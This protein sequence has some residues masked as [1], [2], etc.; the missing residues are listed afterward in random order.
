MSSPD[1][2]FEATPDLTGPDLPSREAMLKRPASKAAH[3]ELFDALPLLK[4]VEVTPPPAPP[5]APPRSARIAF[6][7]A[8]RCKFV[9]ASADLIA[10]LRPDALLLAEMDR[11]MARSGQIHTTRAL[12]Q[13]LEMGGVFGA[14]FVELAL[15]DAK[16]RSHHAGE[17][18]REGLHGGAILSPYRL[19]RPALLRL[20]RD[21][22][23]FDGSRKGERRVGGRIAMLATLAVGD[24]AVTLAA[25]HL[26][27]HSD[28]AHR[29]RQTEL[30]IDAIEAYAPGQPAVIGGD[31]N[32]NTL[33]TS[34]ENSGDN[35]S[36]LL[37]DAP[38]R[39]LDPVT[40]EPLFELLT[41][42]GYDWR[43]CNALDVATQR[44]RPGDRPPPLGKIDWIFTRGLA[45]RDA[46]TVAAIDGSGSPI[47]DH[48]LIMATVELP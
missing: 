41:A 16:E 3:A 39:F 2:S 1:L 19:R 42:R 8:E 30:L 23:W 9:G 45:A 34:E 40:Y 10:P 33:K 11:G 35:R 36:F 46:R 27:S 7:N 32:T 14:E 29:A 18:N 12:A 5:S 44:E 20:D 28:P 25:V 21:G 6:W 17:Q 22:T 48:E 15:G 26:E 31:F 47:S 4:Q 13:K 37:R 43:T 38:T 24:G